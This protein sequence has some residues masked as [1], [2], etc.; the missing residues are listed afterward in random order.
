MIIPEDYLKRFKVEHEQTLFPPNWEAVKVNK[1][2]LCS[3]QLKFPRHGKIA[4][5]NST[6]HGKNF[7]IKTETLN[8][9]K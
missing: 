5:C 6:K 4:F 8:K 3:C 7:I 9:F 1:C 2:P